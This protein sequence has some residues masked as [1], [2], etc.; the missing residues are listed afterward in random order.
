MLTL[1]LIVKMM[2]VVRIKR[3]LNERQEAGEENPIL[4][5]AGEVELPAAGGRLWTSQL[6]QEQST[7]ERRSRRATP[8]VQQGSVPRM[9][10]LVLIS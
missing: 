2:L 1:L 3:Y 8:A 10:L 4:K 5:R 6:S 9:L 7:G